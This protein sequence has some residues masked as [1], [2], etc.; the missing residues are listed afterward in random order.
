MAHISN[1]LEHL[2]AAIREDARLGELDAIAE[3]AASGLEADLQEAEHDLIGWI[4][5]CASQPAHDA[6]EFFAD[7]RKL[8]DEKVE[9]I[10]SALTDLQAA[11]AALQS[12]V[13]TFLADVAAALTA[14]AG[15]P[16]A[17]EAV[18]T[19]INNEVSLLQSNDPS[20]PAAPP[21][22]GSQP[23]Q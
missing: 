10:M 22:D 20:T 16:D 13:S 14:A 6:R 4:T 21:A 18:V 7:I 19:D 23:A 5:R 15:D 9:T 12:E 11:D 17:V 3:K 1:L 8:L 2:R